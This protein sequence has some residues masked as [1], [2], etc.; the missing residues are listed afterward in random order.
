MPRQILFVQGGG[1]AVHDTWDDKLVGSLEREL[2][3]GYAVRYPRMPREAD[4][5]YSV[6]KAA[7]LSELDELEDGAVLI[8]H[9][10]GGAVLLHVLAEERL[11]F[12]PGAL[13]LIAAP[14]IGEGGWTGG[15]I[16]PCTDLAERLPAGMPVFFY[17][18]TED[19]IVPL[20]HVHLHAKAVP[21]AT[22]RVLSHRD[23]QLNNDLGEVA[24][25]IQPIASPSSGAA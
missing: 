18:G 13:L 1:E 15:D 3:H 9:S 4:P 12:S 22:I 24:R 11:K 25:D 14:F 5:N 21:Q 20:A 8:G 16:N 6:W 7:L 10:V 2:G 19:T 23:H 17:H